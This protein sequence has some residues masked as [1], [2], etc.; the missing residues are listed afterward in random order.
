IA[1]ADLLVMLVDGREGLVSG[2]ETIAR[3]LREANRP[4]ILTINKSDDKRSRHQTMD[5]YRRGFEPVVEIS[6]EHGQGV[7]ELLDEIVETLK[8]K[9]L[10]RVAVSGSLE[11]EDDGI[12]SVAVEE[13]TVAIVGRPN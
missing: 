5:F 6:A 11:A 1:A 4:V 7:A 2:D 9:G 8:A 10:G 12:P 13:T 3:E